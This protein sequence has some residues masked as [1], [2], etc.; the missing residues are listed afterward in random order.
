MAFI[1]RSNKAYTFRINMVPP[2]DDA[3]TVTS[4]QPAMLDAK[5]GKTSVGF[6][7]VVL[8]PKTYAAAGIT[9]QV[10]STSGNNSANLLFDIVT[11]LPEQGVDIANPETV[12][13]VP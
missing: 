4:S 3:L 13:N 7:A 6:P 9:V 1:L 8:T 10:V 11:D 12:D 2:L 5:L